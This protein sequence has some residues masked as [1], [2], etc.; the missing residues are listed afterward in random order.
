MSGPLLHTEWRNNNE[1]ISYPFADYATLV[2]RNGDAVDRDLFDDAR[3]Y[4]IGGTVGIHLGKISVTGSEL[5]FHIHDLSGELASGAFDF[6]A[7]PSEVPLYDVYG[8]PAGIL[9]STA[10]R[11]GALDGIYG[12]GEVEFERE[13]TEFAASVVVPMPSPG[14]RGI[15]LDDGNVLSGDIWLVGED[16]V[17]LRLDDSKIRVDVIG[18]PYVQDKDCEEEGA[19]LPQFCGLRSINQITPND[20]GD[21]KLRVGG[22]LVGDPVIRI[23]PIIN[24]VRVE[25]V[26]L[27]G[28]IDQNA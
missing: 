9:V 8:R 4:P 27:K 14:V 11:L 23:V 10:E 25:M 18:D 17:V 2:N 19:P 20:E 12:E 26:G 28:G 24:G 7:P 15:L 5:T 16:G 6:G 22:N 3:L 1:R 21:F 13:Q